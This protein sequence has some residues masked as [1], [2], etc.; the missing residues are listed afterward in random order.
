MAG[1]VVHVVVAVAVTQV[2]V[3]VLQAAA[4]VD[5]APPRINGVTRTTL[6][7][8]A[9]A[10]PWASQHLLTRTVR[11][12]PRAAPD[13][14]RHLFLGH[15]GTSSHRR[16]HP[17]ERTRC[18]AAPR[19]SRRWLT[20]QPSTALST[21]VTQWP[22]YLGRAPGRSQRHMRRRGG[23]AF[24]RPFGPGQLS[25]VRLPTEHPTDPSNRERSSTGLGS[26]AG[27]APGE[28]CA[29]LVGE[30]DGDQPFGLRWLGVGAGAHQETPAE[31]RRCRRYR[32]DRAVGC[33]VR[34]SAAGVHRVLCVPVV[35]LAG[36]GV[37]LR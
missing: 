21:M 37:D 16:D 4:L 15:D 34:C 25:D 1:C 3:R 17:Q 30:R 14:L 9:T 20:H 33:P 31:A 11:R 2:E 12:T 35:R 13:L 23:T 27:A 18:V 7:P 10:A 8:R 29:D 36:V 5:G 6:C 22:S 32:T 19:H 28:R 26:S 24:P